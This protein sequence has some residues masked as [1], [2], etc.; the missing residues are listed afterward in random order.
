MVQR[1]LLLMCVLA[2]IGCRS[3]GGRQMNR[4]SETRSVQSQSD[5]LEDAV[6]DLQRAKTP[7]AEADALR[8]IRKY[9]RDNGLTYTVNSFRTFDNQAVADASTRRDPVRVEVTIF[10]GRE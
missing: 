3:G 9:E 5:A 1:I 4:P 8:R 10:R 6:T 2:M 7:Q